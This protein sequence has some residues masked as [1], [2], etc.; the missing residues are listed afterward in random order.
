MLSLFCDILFSQALRGLDERILSG[1][2][3]D[4]QFALRILPRKNDMKEP[5]VSILV[6]CFNA[7]KTIAGVIQSMRD[8][9]Y[10]K[11]QMIIVDDG[12]HDVGSTERIIAKFSDKRI[13]FIRETHKGI[14]ATIM[15]AFKSSRGQLVTIHGADDLSLP[16]RLE[17]TV[18]YFS[19]NP[20]TDVF[21][22]AIYVSAWSPG[23]S[24]IVRQYRQ[25]MPARRKE[26]LREQAVIGVPI[27]KREVL[28]AC[29]IREETK[30][31]FDWM[32]HLDFVY[33]GFKYA[34]SD[35]PLYEY[36][37]HLNSASERFEKAGER[38]QS[39]EAIAKIMLTEYDVTFMP[40]E[41][42]L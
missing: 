1:Q 40:K 12:S 22:H 2:K 42:A 30:F 15:R 39:L 41:W 17:R 9:T 6:P 34:I 3:T 23:L 20:D 4:C 5:L 16:D 35:R 33:K 21:V 27:F 8:Q 31:A 14:P 13:K 28:K 10:E 32:M 37:R 11:W 29:P 26:L 7:S 36:V 24:C 25:S 19:E 38:H 18:K